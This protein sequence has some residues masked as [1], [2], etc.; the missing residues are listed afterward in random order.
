MAQLAKLAN[1]S[2]KFID[3][4]YGGLSF[5]VYLADKKKG[6]NMEKYI[7]WYNEQKIWVKVVLAIFWFPAFFYRLF[8]LILIHEKI[9]T[10]QLAY[11]ILTIIPAVGFI[12]VI[13]DVIYAFK[14]AIPLWIDLDTE[15]KEEN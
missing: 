3:P 7:E 5:L 9:P 13:I 1:S 12:F 6:K 10:A 8:K 14:G 15:E 2:K 4:L 11:F